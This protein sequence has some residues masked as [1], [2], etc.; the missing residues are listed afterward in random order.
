[1]I[2]NTTSFSVTVCVLAAIALGLSEGHA[3]TQ[4]KGK[5]AKRY[6]YATKGVMEFQSQVGPGKVEY[7][8]LLLDQMPG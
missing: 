1:M 2:K 5:E 6:S 4:E 7:W 3:A 8:K